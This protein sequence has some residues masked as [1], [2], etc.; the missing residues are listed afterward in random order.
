MKTWRKR[1]DRLDDIIM[2]ALNERFE[3]VKQIGLHKKET[4]LSVTDANREKQI[5]QK[6]EY[7]PHSDKI[8]PVYKTIITTAKNYQEG[9]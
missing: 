6:S 4:G 1:I 5:Y 2:D 3:L 9:L 8:K 7:Y